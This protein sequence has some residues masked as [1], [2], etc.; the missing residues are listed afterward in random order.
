[1]A[2]TWSQGQW[3]LGTWNNSVSGAALT[4]IDL[5][6]SSGSFAFNLGNGSVFTPNGISTTVDLNFGNGW[7]REEWNTGAWNEG[8]GEVVTGDGII[9]IEDGQGLT[10]T[11]NN[12]SVIGSTS[13]AITGDE[14]T[15]S[16]NNVSSILAQASVTI[17]GEDLVT[18]AVD[19]FAVA[20][21]GSIT[22]N[23]PTFEA[24]VELSNSYVVGTANFIT[25]V[26]NSLTTSL[27]TI[28][29]NSENIIDITGQEL[30][31]TANTIALSTDQILSITGNQ[32]TVSAATIIPNSN[33]FLSITGNQANVD[34]NTIQF[35]NP[36][37][38]TITEEWT[39]IH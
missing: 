18:A 5:T 34:V 38:P 21:G 14:I 28:I 29:P 23:T 2:S 7:N 32:V 36:I 26:G 1:M 22:I 39:N 35:W 15:L 24:N 17:T 12:I 6:V 13:F 20:A 25:I 8:I 4:G 16:L 30:T 19:S 10:T 11:A 33:N 3:N 27:A 37:L 31:L 9:F